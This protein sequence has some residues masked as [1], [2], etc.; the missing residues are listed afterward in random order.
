MNGGLSEANIHAANVLPSRTI[1]FGDDGSLIT[2]EVDPAFDPSTEYGRYHNGGGNVVYLD[3]HV[4][5][6]PQR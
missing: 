6:L 2:G 3:G 1:L 5:R 4:D